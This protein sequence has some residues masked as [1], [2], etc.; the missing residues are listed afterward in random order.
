VVEDDAKAFAVVVDTSV[1][2]EES[3]DGVTGPASDDDPEAVV[4]A[5]EGGGRCRAVAVGCVP[6]PEATAISG[7]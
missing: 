3:D 6:H 5:T 1:D 7:I 2:V 4:P